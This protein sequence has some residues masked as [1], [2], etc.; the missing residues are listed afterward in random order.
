M[1]DS[2]VACGEK[3]AVR[4]EG[5]IKLGSLLGAAGRRA[6]LTDEEFVAFA[7]RDATPGRPVSFENK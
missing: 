6:A 3:D 1:P 2:S 5:R 4:P 7:C